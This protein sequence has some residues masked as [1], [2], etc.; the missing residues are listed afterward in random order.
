MTVD[1]KP[2]ESCIFFWAELNTPLHLRS[3]LPNEASPPNSLFPLFFYCQLR[4]IFEVYFTGDLCRRFFSHFFVP[5]SPA[6]GRPAAPGSRFN[7]RTSGTSLPCHRSAPL[8]RAPTT[9]TNPFTQAGL[10]LRA[11]APLSEA[12]THTHSAHKSHRQRPGCPT[13]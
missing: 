11:R 2:Q 6:A 3:I 7:T 1:S 10:H 9:K 4:G 5:G 13:A 8:G 12:Q